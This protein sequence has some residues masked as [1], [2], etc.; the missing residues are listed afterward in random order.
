MHI[1]DVIAKGAYPGNWS[2]YAQTSSGP[3]FVQVTVLFVS[4]WKVFFIET[5]IGKLDLECKICFIEVV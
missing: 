3:C 1:I 5:L 2:V 4:Y